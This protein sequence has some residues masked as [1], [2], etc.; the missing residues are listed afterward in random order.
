MVVDSK[1]HY[2]TKPEVN[3]IALAIELDAKLV[4]YKRRLLV[5]L[6]GKY[7]D[8]SEWRVEQNIQAAEKVSKQL[9]HMGYSVICPQK[10]TAHFGS[11]D[12][13]SSAFIEGDMVM[14][15]RSDIVVMLDNWETSSGALLERRLALKLSI[16][17]YYWSCHQL[18]LQRLCQNDYRYRDA[19]AAILG[20]A[21]RISEVTGYRTA[22]EHVAASSKEVCDSCGTP[23]GEGRFA[24]QP[25]SLSKRVSDY[26]GT[27]E[28][29]SSAAEAKVCASV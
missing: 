11:D 17:V 24:N 18:A 8:T 3:A 27:F 19:R 23:R 2:V 22:G 10:N 7:R 16:P 5:Y 1:M 4:K 25:V 26:L 9:W 13:D 28:S 21:S 15:E 6:S 29:K 14:V 12:I 20:R